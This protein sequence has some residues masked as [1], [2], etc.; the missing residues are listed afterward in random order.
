MLLAVLALLLLALGL[1]GVYLTQPTP[2][3]RV[4]DREVA[5]GDPARLEAHVAKLVKLSPRSFEE[6]S[7][8]ARVASYIRGEL[9]RAG[10]AVSEQPVGFVG[11][12]YRNIL[13][14]F[15]PE[16]GGRIVVGAHYDACGPYPGA[17]DNAS[18][19]AGLLEL[20]RLLGD[21]KLGTRVDLVAFTLEEPPAFGSPLMGSAVHAASLKQ[22][23]VRVLAMI[24][25]EM[26]GCFRD[27]A[28]SQG[29]PVP[30]LRLLY[31]GEG[32]FIAVAGRL[33]GGGLTRGIKSSMRRASELPVRSVNGPRWML[34][35]DLSDH[36]S[37]WNAGYPAVMITDTAFYRNPRYH[38]ADDL[39]ATLDYVRMAEV[40]RG[41]HAAVLDLAC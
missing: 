17:D 18:G 8:L 24:C 22:A 6:A 36:A 35:I 12:S 19:V 14:S 16:A 21:A 5:G 10:A 25:L 3:V 23:G 37:Y 7:N 15:G 1:G 39:P 28:G 27:E 34:G 2:F 33:G 4:H 26:I 20:S 9:E 32:N 13:A 31:P 30:V 29:F 41:V 40:V 11:K 38:E